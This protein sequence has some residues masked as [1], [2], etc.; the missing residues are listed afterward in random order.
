M[1]RSWWWRAVL[2]AGITVLACLA[3]V[4][5]VLPDH[6]M[7]GGHYQRRIQRGLDLQGGLRLV[8]TVDLEKAG[9]ARSE[10]RAEEIREA[11]IEIIRRRVDNLGLAEPNIMKRGGEIVVELPGVKPEDFERI[12]LIVGST[13]QLEFKL[14]DDEADDYMKKVIARLPGEGPIRWLRDAWP[15]SQPGAER[16]L[17][18]L[19]TT[20]RE[21]LAGFL[22]SLT[23]LPPPAGKTWGFE[24]IAIRGEATAQKLWRSYLLEQRATVTGQHL[25]GADETWDEMGQPLVAFTMDRQGAR[26]MEK[27]TGANV[28]RR[29]AILLDE[30]I[31]S[32]P[33]IDEQIGEHG[34]IRMGGALDP[35]ALGREVKDLVT[36]LRSGALPAPLEK[37]FETQVGPS[38]GEDAVSRAKLAMSIGAVAVVLFMLLYYRLAGVVANVAMV[39][40]MLYI[41][42]ILASLEASLTLPGIAGLVLTIGMAVDANIIIYERIREELRLG[43]SPASAVNAGFS[44][45]FWTVFDAHVTNFVAGVILFSFGSG[46]VRGFALTLLIGIATNLLTSVWIS[47]WMFQLVVRRRAATLSI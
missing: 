16:D 3:V 43:R 14:V 34:S 27:F 37:S 1:E 23:D 17:I 30:K 7:L 22:A 6:R 5:T 35:A 44:R 33:R 2:F 13:A 31:A 12:K 46:P 20:R 39:L 26:L 11:S 10:T 47:R 41:L 42:A 24:E 40:N 9:A 21:E 4:P 38:L 32:A 29:M 8:Y 28:G 18:C 36:V 45:A 25:A 19:E 15:A